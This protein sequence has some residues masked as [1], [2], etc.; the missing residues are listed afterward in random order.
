M[1]KI[2]L[3]LLLICSFSAHIFA[4]SVDWDFRYGNHNMDEYGK[5]IAID[6]CGNLYSIGYYNSDV[7]FDGTMAN[8]LG[9]TTMVLLK[10]STNGEVKSV[11][12]AGGGNAKTRGYSVEVDDQCNVYVAGSWTSGSISFD[13]TPLNGTNG[14]FVAKI[15][16]TGDLQWIK[17]NNAETNFES[18]VGLSLSPSGEVYVCSNFF[19]TIQVEN[20]S[21]TA[22][23]GDY[24]TFIAK[25]DNDGALI[26]TKKY[27]GIGFESA[28]E[29]TTDPQGNIYMAG[30][31]T[32]TAF[33]G[34]NSINAG[35]DSDAY[36]V[37]IDPTGSA[38]WAKN[39]TEIEAYGEALAVDDEGN[40]YLGGNTDDEGFL[41]KFDTDGNLDWSKVLISTSSLMA[42]VYAIDIGPL[43]NPYIAGSYFNL[44]EIDETLIDGGSFEDAFFAKLDKQGVVKWASYYDRSYNDMAEGMV[45]SKSG[46]ELYITGRGSESSLTLYNDYLTFNVSVPNTTGIH[47][48][49]TAPTFVNVFPNP[50]DSDFTFE[51]DDN[52]SEDNSIEL[53]DSFGKLVLRKEQVSNSTIT[54]QKDQLSAGIYFYNV[55]N[56]ANQINRGKIVVQ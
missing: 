10:T 21:L 25:Y 45:V 47:K 39:S 12:L 7:D 18:A 34:G 13:G 46:E 23:V 27:G 43:G 11:M 19:G 15:N 22:N 16:S 44:L 1:K 8:A 14:V 41:Q 52:S 24:D 38:L 30:S 36:V 6:D 20:A 40:V 9:S 5:D 53:Y 31:F 28:N 55:K 54:I 56:S 35:A 17:T 42:S 51:F 37:K 32:K 49:E 2:I 33:F 50:T 48:L 4:Q 29:I 26:W 3:S